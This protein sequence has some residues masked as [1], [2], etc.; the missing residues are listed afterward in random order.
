MDKRGLM[1]TKGLFGVGFRLCVKT[2]LHSYM[3]ENVFHLQVHFHANQTYFHMKDF[4]QGLVL[5]EVIELQLL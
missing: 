3:H 2:Y 1:S 4:V 5:K